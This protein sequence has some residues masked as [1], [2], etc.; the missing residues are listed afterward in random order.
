MVYLVIGGLT[1][2]TILMLWLQSQ[3]LTFSVEGETGVTKSGESA[4]HVYNTCTGKMLK[5]AQTPLQLKEP[6]YS[7]LDVMKLGVTFTTAL[8]VMLYLG[9]IGNPHETHWKRVG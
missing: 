7:L 3:E 9:M 8:W 4:L 2:W 1:I 5:P 6:W